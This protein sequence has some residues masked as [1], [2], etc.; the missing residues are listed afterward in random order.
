MFS[1]RIC[2]YSKRPHRVLTIVYERLVSDPERETKR[3][4]E[5]LGVEW[6]KQMMY[7]GR[8]KHMGEQAIC[9]EVWY[10]KRA[11]NRN[12]EA[13]EINKWKQQLSSLQKIN[14]AMAFKDFEELAPFGYD[15]SVDRVSPVN[16]MLYTVSCI[17]THT[18]PLVTRAS[19]QLWKAI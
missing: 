6:S 19:R 3:I 17:P 12:P 15:F 16:R 10:D 7:P 8:Q 2:R 9:N 18:I 14:I 13:K 1:G 11:Y 5:F 4:C